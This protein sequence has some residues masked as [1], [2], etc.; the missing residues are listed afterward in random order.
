MSPN[1]QAS[2]ERL[3]RQFEAWLDRI[4]ASEEPPD[5]IDAELLSAL[6]TG[7][8]PTDSREY[9]L[10]SLWSAMT[11]LA[12]EVKLQ[13]RTFKQLNDTLAPLAEMPMMLAKE[14]NNVSLERQREAE[15]R[16]RKQMLD[17]LLDLRDRLGRGHDSVKEA[18][19]FMASARPSGWI[20]RL[21]RRDG[22]R[23]EQTRETVAALQKGYELSVDRLDGALRD[24]NVR[25][26]ACLGQIFD[27]RR[28]N[29]V[30]TEETDTAPDGTV[31]AVYRNGYEW[32]G[33]LYRPAQ[34]RVARTKNAPQ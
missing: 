7:Q 14:E 22:E 19:A 3:L 5:G 27:P 1:D 33:E 9:D 20:D 2:K 34:V 6:E 8:E 30:E 21:L 12:Q 26:I 28:M 29:A 13:G 24:F 11:A 18:E 31:V 15:S 10:Y 16:A 17:L 4:L 32:N 25:P 23:A